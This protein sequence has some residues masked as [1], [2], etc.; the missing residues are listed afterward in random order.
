MTTLGDLAI[1]GGIQTGPFGSQLHASD[2][3]D[4][5]VGVVM[6]QDLGDNVVRPDAMARVPSETAVELSRHRLR[7]GDIV[8]SRRGDVTRRALIREADGELLC[9]TGC[10]R[11]R[12]DLEKADPVF[13][14]YAMAMKESRDWL[15]RHAVGATMPNLNTGILS[16]LPARS[17]RLQLQRA[18]GEVLGALDDKIAVNR[19]I[20]LGSDS[21]V[22]AMYRGLRASEWTL[23]QVASNIRDSVSR[24]NIADDEMYVGLEH[25][26]RKTLW[27]EG[28]GVGIGVA[29]SKSRFA[30]GDVLFGKLRPYF[31]KVALAPSSGVC[32]TDILVVRPLEKENWAL[33]A[34]ATSSDAAISAAVQASNGTKMPR[35][36]WDDVARVRV[37][38]PGATETRTFGLAV[39]AIAR[40]AIQVS[41]ESSQIAA[42]RNELLPL[43][44]S[45]KI[46]VK[47]AEKAVEEVV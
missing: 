45:G 23:G 6:P 42:T 1:E 44:I 32:S 29:S 4:H 31:H 47:D 36:K 10:L 13:V 40:R 37:P 27:L 9:G 38:D 14:S 5:G 17:P 43:L 41:D 11:V 20:M 39:E 33:V 30:K 25:L 18:V 3:T 26:G 19:S 7:P 15:I 21:L 28:R 46:T 12:L 2:Y 24:E 22:R 16:R 34:A 35:A 8:F